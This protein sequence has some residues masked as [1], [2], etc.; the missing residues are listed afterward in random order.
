MSDTGVAETQVL[1]HSCATY[2]VCI[3]KKLDLGA[4]LE[5]ETRHSTP[6]R[7]LLS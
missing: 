3:S 6:P 1:R 2:R 4:E 7:M 5:L